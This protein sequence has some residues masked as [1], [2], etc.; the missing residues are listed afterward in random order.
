MSL[1]GE[2]FKIVGSGAGILG[3]CYYLGSVFFR[4]FAKDKLER[5][6]D[7][8]ETDIV[9]SQYLRIKELEAANRDITEKYISSASELGEVKGEVRA[10]TMHSKQLEGQVDALQK[11]VEAMQRQI[12]ELSQGIKND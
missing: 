2:S 3:A 5:V 6:K 8:T 1:D 9:T 12:N 11:T 4:R 7:R 10:L